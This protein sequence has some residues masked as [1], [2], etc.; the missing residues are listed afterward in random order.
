MRNFIFLLILQAS[1]QAVAQDCDIVS[2]IQNDYLDDAKIL[3]LREIYSDST[4]SNADSV[5]I[6]SSLTDKYL[7]ALSVIY[8]LDNQVIDSIFNIYEI[9]SFPNVPYMEIAMIGDTNYTWIKNYMI[10]SVISGNPHFDS[11]V[12]KYDFKLQSYINL[13]LGL[14]M[15]ITTPRY[16]NLEPIVDS[17]NAI[18]GLVLVD[19]IE[20]LAGDGN[21]IEFSTDNDTLF[22]DFSIGWGDCPAGCIN[23]QYWH[24]SVFDCNATYLG[25]SGDNFTSA[26]DITKNDYNLYPNPVNDILIIEKWD[27]LKKIDVYDFQGK[28]I[29]GFNNISHQLNLSGLKT[30]QYLLMIQ[31]RNNNESIFK[32]IKR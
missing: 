26:N 14:S 27:N 23:R 2:K 16:L 5:E 11:I 4:S 20:S 30:G 3:A 17:L 29:I 7:G 24:F 22:I 10:D 25:L 28:K 1:L 21:N 19:A 8:S 12:T 18:E 6:P 31:N 32:L 9:H 15:R 13:S